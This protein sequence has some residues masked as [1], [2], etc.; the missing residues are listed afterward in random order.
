MTPRSEHFPLPISL[1]SLQMPWTGLWFALQD[2]NICKLHV[3]TVSH[4]V[5]AP[6]CLFGY[7]FMSCIFYYL[8]IL[9]KTD[10][11]HAALHIFSSI[12]ETAAE[13]KKKQKHFLLIL[14][15]CYEVYY[16]IFTFLDTETSINIIQA[17]CQRTC[18][19]T[20]DVH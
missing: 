18:R 1:T 7:S 11:V 2:P 14:R 16:D 17:C 9:S 19:L 5:A 12:I 13:I 20:I 6:I 3:Y 15:I 8:N 10:I 4:S